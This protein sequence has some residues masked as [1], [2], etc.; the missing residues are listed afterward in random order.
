MTIASTQLKTV[1]SGEDGTNQKNYVQIGFAIE[2]S[3][4][5]LTAHAGG[6]Q[7]NAL[8][9]L[10]EINRITT[11]AIANDSVALPKSVAGMTVIVINHGANPMQVF[12]NGTDTINDAAAATGVSQMQNSVVIYMCAT[13][14]AWYTDGLANGFAAGFQTFSSVDGL[15]AH[16]GGGQGSATP[17]TAMQNLFGTVASAGDS[18]VLPSAKPGMQIDVINKTATSMNVFPAVGEQINGAAANSAVAVV[19]GSSGSVTVFFC[20]TAG[21]WWTK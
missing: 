17:I 19:G 7:A 18:A 6:G 1:P 15:V 11:V 13:A 12:G 10:N 4:D 14:G 5:N 2:S 16:A 9:L 21:Q 8:P 20:G 3:A